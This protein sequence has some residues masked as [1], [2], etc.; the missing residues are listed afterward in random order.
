MASPVMLI[1]NCLAL[2][3][4]CSCSKPETRSGSLPS[5]GG[6][7]GETKQTESGAFDTAITE[8]T[9][10]IQGDP[11]NPEADFKRAVS[12]GK[13][14]PTPPLPISRRPWKLSLTAPVRI[15]AGGWPVKRKETWTRPLPIT[16][17]PSN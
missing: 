15:S 1:V 5:G 13:A 14:T 12:R 17:K 6:Q 4:V 2:M 7:Q 10:A 8:A 11:Q 16:R 3:T 9:Q